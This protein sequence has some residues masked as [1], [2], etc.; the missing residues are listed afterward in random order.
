MSGGPE[1]PKGVANM[2]RRIPT[3]LSRWRGA[4]FALLCLFAWPGTAA[5]DGT[6]PTAVLLAAG[7]IAQCDL[8]GAALTTGLIERQAGTVLALG[9]LAY[10]RGTAADFARCYEPTWGHFKSRT[11]PVPGNHDYKIPGAA[12]YFAYFGARAGKPG[13]GYY[14]VDLPGWHIV[15]LN[16]NIDSGPD[17]EQL[18]W[19]Q[20]DLAGNRQSCILAFWHHPRF[21][22][23]YHGDTAG[24]AAMWETLYA[25]GAGIVLSGHEHNYERFAPLDAKGNPDERRGIRSFVVGTGGAKPYDLIRA[26]HEHSEAWYGQGWGV[27]RLRLYPGRY[28]WEFLPA[29]SGTFRDAG[30]GECPKP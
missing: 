5:Q 12:A 4:A 17:S 30:A 21:T 6:P 27:L 8:L 14:S 29:G 15:A 28:E 9:D 1:S 20:T 16:S 3:D 26:R 13:K 25:S 7:D 10:P 23:G 11:L 2:G 18:K 22:S 19:L 24:V